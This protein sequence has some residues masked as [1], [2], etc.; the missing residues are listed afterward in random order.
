MMDFDYSLHIFR[1]PKFQ[2]VVN[3]AIEFFVETPLHRLPPPNQFLGPGVYGLYYIGVYELY[4][5]I[6]EL[7]RSTCVQPIYVGKAVPPGWRTARTGTS[8]TFDL[9]QRLR[10]HT[11]SIQQGANLD[12]DDFRCKFMILNGI[13]SDLIVPVEAELIRRF[14]PLWNTL[15]DGF[16]N[17]DPGAGRYNQARSEWDV[18]HPGRLWAVRLTGAS[19]KLEN[20]IA[21]VR[22]ALA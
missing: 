20:V 13:E 19:P 14:M 8:E 22:L 7:N 3:E 5:K 4:A 17:H 6:S 2:S 21:K 1:S 11:R 15:V 12:I 16:G 18:L 9:Y 10:E